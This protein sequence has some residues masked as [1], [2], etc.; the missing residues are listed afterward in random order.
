MRKA[1]AK[2]AGATVTPSL[3]NEMLAHAA[4]RQTD[5]FEGRELVDPSQHED[6]A[7]DPGRV[8]QEPGNLLSQLRGCVG[9]EV[10]KPTEERPDQQV[11]AHEDPGWDKGTPASVPLT[12]DSRESQVHR[13][14]CGKH[15]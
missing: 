1:H 2:G 9:A 8:H 11:C 3:K 12:L 13:G 6:A 7:A 14:R 10:R 15:H 4:F 5:A